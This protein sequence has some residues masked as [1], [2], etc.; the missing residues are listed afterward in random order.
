[1][2]NYNLLNKFVGPP[3]PAASNSN[4]GSNNTKRLS[5]GS[6]Q[7][8]VMTRGRTYLTNH[9]GETSLSSSINKNN[10]N[11]VN[12]LISNNRSASS[13]AAATAYHPLTFHHQQQQQQL[14]RLIATQ[15]TCRMITKNTNNYGY[16]S[17]NLYPSVNNIGSTISGEF[18]ERLQI[19]AQYA[20]PR[21]YGSN[22]SAATSSSVGGVSGGYDKF[23][24]DADGMS[25]VY[26]RSLFPHGLASSS[27]QHNQ[28]DLQT[29]MFNSCINEKKF[30]IQQQQQQQSHHRH[31]HHHQGGSGHHPLTASLAQV[32][33]S[34]TQ[35]NPQANDFIP[36]GQPSFS[37]EEAN[38]FIR[39]QLALQ[40]H[41]Q[42][43]K[44]SEAAKSMA[45]L[46]EMSHTIIAE[47]EEARHEPLGFENRFYDD[48]FNDNNKFGPNVFENS[49]VK[50]QERTTEQLFDR[51]FQ[52]S[53]RQLWYEPVT[54]TISSRQGEIDRAQSDFDLQAFNHELHSGMFGSL[55]LLFIVSF[56]FLTINDIACFS[57]RKSF[58]EH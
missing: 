41:N 30:N 33:A 27:Y 10:N 3:A 28:S 21:S 55:Y 4:V 51:S 15:S 37:I 56:I 44:A 34:S 22:A 43:F 29:A 20:I 38:R 9:G 50:K 24:R 23:P 11:F 47:R 49:P 42:Q 16:Q 13:V 40:C 32:I 53:M 14:N 12:N 1:M 48:R 39:K 57:K 8:L 26:S 6:Q 35:L 18:D 58:D 7:P 31:H 45:S 17:P 54:T 36:N 2:S 46:Q 25:L 19:G 5:L 52:S